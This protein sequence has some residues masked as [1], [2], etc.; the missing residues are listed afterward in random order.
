[1]RLQRAKIVVCDV[2]GVDVVV[3][4]IIFSRWVD[5]WKRTSVHDGVE[6]MGVE[7]LIVV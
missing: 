5:S 4:I 3:A 2:Q 1:M 6:R 7:D